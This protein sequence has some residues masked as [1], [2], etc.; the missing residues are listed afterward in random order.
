MARSHRRKKLILTHCPENR[1]LTRINKSLFKRNLFSPFLHSRKN[2]L[3][4]PAA[5]PICFL[6]LPYRR[7]A[8]SL[9]SECQR[10]FPVSYGV[11]RK[12]SFPSHCE[13]S[14]TKQSG[15]FLWIS[16]LLRP[17]RNDRT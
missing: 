7:A 8:A 11:V 3:S 15:V 14:S 2:S 10:K 6:Q 13:K 16:G 5:L 12:L 1:V 17:A 9:S 4:P